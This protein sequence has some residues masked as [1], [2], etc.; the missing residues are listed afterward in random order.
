MAADNTHHQI[1]EFK[2]DIERA[3]FA[4]YQL[5]E[6]IFTDEISPSDEKM[7]KQSFIKS[8]KE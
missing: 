7:L 8:S 1:R 2:A 6:R 3:I 4:A 5:I